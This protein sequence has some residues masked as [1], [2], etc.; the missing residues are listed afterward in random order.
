MGK[1]VVYLANLGRYNEGI[2]QGSW[3]K[4]P[5]STEALEK[6]LDEIGIN[7]MYEE[8]FIIDSESDIL[9]INNAINE[10]SSIQKL[11]EL[12]E[13]LE[14]LPADDERKLEAVLEYENCFWYK[15]Y[16]DC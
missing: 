4:L 12:A 2:L 1:M 3:L 14:L 7:E 13:C 15:N 10:F 9:G 6:V 11:N 16:V 5:A 8:Y